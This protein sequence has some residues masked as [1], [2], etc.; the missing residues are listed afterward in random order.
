[1]SVEK[2]FHVTVKFSRSDAGMV[3]SVRGKNDGQEFTQEGLSE[4]DLE[5]TR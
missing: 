5:Y 2:T 1:M 3:K 4:D